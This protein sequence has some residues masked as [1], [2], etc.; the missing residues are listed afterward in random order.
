LRT[1]NPADGTVLVRGAFSNCR[2]M[3]SRLKV[4]ST[5]RADVP[6]HLINGQFPMNLSAKHRAKSKR[7]TLPTGRE[8]REEH[9]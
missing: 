2:N 9:L 5:I 8:R 7:R 6:D 4:E 3:A 1:G